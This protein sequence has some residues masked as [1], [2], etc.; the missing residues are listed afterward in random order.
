MPRRPIPDLSVVLAFL[1][2]G[3]GWSQT[4]LGEAAGIS[5][6]LVND[7][8]W[9]RK[10][11]T[12]ERLEHLIAFLGLPPQA[13]D[14][15]L[16][17]L[18]SSRALVR[19]AAGG[20][21]RFGP[22][23]RRIEA[24]AARF[25]RLAA[26]FGRSMLAM[27]TVEGEALYARQ[28]AELLWMRLKKRSAAERRKRVEDGRAFRTWALCERVAAESIERAANH[29]RES[30]ELAELALRIAEL[31]PGEE[32]WRWRLQGYALFHVANARRVCSDVPGSVAALARARKLWKDGAPG[33]PEMLNPAIPFWIEAAVR[34]DQRRFKEA[35]RCI[36][37]ALSLERGELRGKMLLS[38]AHILATLGDPVASTAA[39]TE[40]TPL[41]DSN[42]E[43]RLA[44]G[45]RFN[46][47]VELCDLNRAREAAAGLPE[48]RALAERLGEELD[49]VR[50]VWLEGKVVAGLG[51][52]EDALAAFE[53]ARRGFRVRELAYDYALVSLDLS[54]VL[55]AEGQLG[56]VRKIAEEMLWIFSAQGIHR[57]ALA[58]LQ[59]FCE[60]AR[61]EVA[62]VD[63]TRSVARFLC[64]ARH[65]PAL[66]FEP[67]SGEGSGPSEDQ[68]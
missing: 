23:R 55:L 39:L 62:T 9:G 64:R 29:P 16:A 65:D 36:D 50:V 14:G 59:V 67:E 61:R 42:R 20:H 33:D 66:R 54:L 40:A 53:Q 4:E 13:I 68:L 11:L 63:L 60:A 37:R 58:A 34:R 6:N 19:D 47:L 31:A 18:A 30:L 32:V 49:L 45:L 2:A 48:V 51:R 26:D 17:C 22:D 46:L 15:A 52:I 28:R 56:E 21:G 41:I 5:P 8:E 24:F 57:E 3:Q 1:R 10:P 35:L 7:Y 27:L 25:G 12:R 44:F 43:P 38:K